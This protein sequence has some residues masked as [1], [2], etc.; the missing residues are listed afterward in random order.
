MRGRVAPESWRG[1]LPITYRL[2]PGPARVHLKLTFD[3]KQTPLYD[4]IAKLPGTTAADEWVVR[5]NHMDGWVN[6]ASD[7]LSGLAP[8]MEEARA[9]GELYKQGWRP[10]RT[11]VYAG[12]DGEEHGLIGSTEWAETHADELQKRAVLSTLSLFWTAAAGSL[13]Q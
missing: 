7:P 1:A 5:G 6:G 13:F 12:W 2:G 8:E 4:V 10:K 11:I 9:M 3:W